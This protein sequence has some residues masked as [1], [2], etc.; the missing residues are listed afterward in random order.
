MAKL[1]LLFVA[2][3]PLLA[4]GII[5]AQPASTNSGTDT[6]TSAR[7]AYPSRPIRLIVPFAAGGSPDITSRVL[8]GELTRQMGQQVIVDNRAGAAGIIG[9]ELVA[10]ATP[11][12]Y[13]L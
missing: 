9:T 13:T 3:L 11:D 4:T 1:S 2:G 10:R 8:V 6:R 5:F 7:N 12:G